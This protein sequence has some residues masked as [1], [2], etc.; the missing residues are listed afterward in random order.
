M[1]TDTYVN[2]PLYNFVI[3]MQFWM[4]PWLQTWVLQLCNCLTAA[5]IKCL[6][7]SRSTFFIKC[8]PQPHILPKAQSAIKIHILQSSFPRPILDAPLFGHDHVNLRLQPENFLLLHQNGV[9]E[10]GKLN[11]KILTLW[12]AHNFVRNCQ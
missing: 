6:L 1:T 5:K 11:W 3:Y 9:Q 2:C 7:A 12:G 8:W 4:C 10:L